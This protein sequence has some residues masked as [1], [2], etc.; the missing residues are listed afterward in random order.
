VKKPDAFDRKRKTR[1]KAI[2]RWVKSKDIV[3]P[4]FIAF[5]V[6]GSI[7]GGILGHVIVPELWTIGLFAGGAVGVIGGSFYVT[8]QL[9]K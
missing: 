3:A 2:K 4:A 1:D 6:M 5:T 7:L 9:S 8:D